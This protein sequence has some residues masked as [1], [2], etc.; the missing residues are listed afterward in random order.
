MKATPETLP[1]RK[2]VELRNLFGG[3]GTSILS[4][5]TLGSCYLVQI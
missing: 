1:F 2:E 3:L 4:L 5:E